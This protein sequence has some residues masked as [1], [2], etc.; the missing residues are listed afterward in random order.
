MDKDKAAILKIVIVVAL[1]VI[2]LVVWFNTVGAPAG[3]E[4]KEVVETA[5]AAKD[6]VESWMTVR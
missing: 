5:F 3:D 6:A 4:E 1:I 2:F